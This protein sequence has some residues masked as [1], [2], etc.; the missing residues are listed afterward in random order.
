MNGSLFRSRIGWRPKISDVVGPI[1]P[2]G[3]LGVISLFRAG[4]ASAGSPTVSTR[5]TTSL[6]PL[7]PPES[8]TAASPA[9]A[10]SHMAAPMSAKAPVKEASTAKWT[11]PLPADTL[12]PPL[13]L[14]LPKPQPARPTRAVTGKTASR[15]LHLDDL[16]RNFNFLHP[17]N[18]LIWLAPNPAVGR[19]S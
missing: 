19:Q 17:P 12:G 18:V 2:I 9:L 7:M 6:R 1:A 4:T 15:D 8:F 10:P 11:G 16:F 3:G 5:S 14:E 13:V